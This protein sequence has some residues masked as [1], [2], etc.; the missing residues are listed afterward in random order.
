MPIVATVCTFIVNSIFIWPTKLLRLR[1]PL[2][3]RR[4]C[5]KSC[6]GR[7]RRSGAASKKAMAS[8]AK[9]C[10][11]TIVQIKTTTI[12]IIITVYKQ[13]NSM[14]SKTAVIATITATTGKAALLKHTHTHTNMCALAVKS[15]GSCA[16]VCVCVG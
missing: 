9:I 13:Y 1:L 7:R 11:T 6:S 12:T 3:G 15:H 16:C 10:Q 14:K 5:R 4:G 8:H 2:A